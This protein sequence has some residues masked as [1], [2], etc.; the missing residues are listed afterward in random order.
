MR[1]VDS[2]YWAE[3][4]QLRPQAIVHIPTQYVRDFDRLLTGGIWA[5]IDMRFKYDEEAKG[6]NPFWIDKLDADPA[7]HL[8]PRRVPDVRARVH[9]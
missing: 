7:R 3:V 5:Q 6:K 2:R 1:L 9:D 8:R 4:S